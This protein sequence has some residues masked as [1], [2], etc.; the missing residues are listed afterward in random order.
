MLTLLLS[1]TLFIGIG[2]S[3]G[4]NNFNFHGTNVIYGSKLSQKVVITGIYYMNF[5]NPQY[6]D[7]VHNDLFQKGILSI[8]KK[9]DISFVKGKGPWVCE[10]N[11]DA[12]LANITQRNHDIVETNL[13][14]MDEGVSV[15][16]IGKVTIFSFDFD[17][18]KAKQFIP[19]QTCRPIVNMKRL[20]NTNLNEYNRKVF[21]FSI[22]HEFKSFAP[23]IFVDYF[24]MTAFHYKQKIT[25]QESLSS[26]GQPLRYCDGSSYGSTMYTPE[27]RPVCPTDTSNHRVHQ[28]GMITIYKPNIVTIS[29]AISRSLYGKTHL[30][31]GRYFLGEKYD[32]KPITTK[33]WPPSE[34]ECLGMRHNLTSKYGKLDPRG[35]G[36]YTLAAFNTHN[37]KTIHYPLWSSWSKDVFDAF[38]EKSV[39]K[40]LMPNMVMRTPWFGIP[41]PYLYKSTYSEQ[42]SRVVWDALVPEDLCLFVP[43]M[44]TEVNAIFYPDTNHLHEETSSSGS[45][46]MGIFI[47]DSVKGAWTVDDKMEINT[48]K[49]AN[50]NCIK[51]PSSNQKLYLLKT[52]EILIYTKDGRFFPKNMHANVW[53]AT[54]AHHEAHSSFVEISVDKGHVTSIHNQHKSGSDKGDGSTLDIAEMYKP[55][56]ENKLAPNKMEKPIP[57]GSLQGEKNASQE[58][59]QNYQTL[60]DQINYLEWQ[61]GEIQRSNVHQRAINNCHQNQLAWDTFTQ[62]LDI[63]PS[64]AIGARLK[65][66]VQATHAGNRVYSVKQCELILNNVI[67]PTLFT[68]SSRKFKING[69]EKGMSEIIQGLGVVPSDRKCLVYPLIKFRIR[70]SG[71]EM[72]GQLQTDGTIDTVHASHME[73]CQHNRELVFDI[74][75]NTSFFKDYILQATIPTKEVK[76]HERALMSAHAAV[77]KMTQNLNGIGFSLGLS[78]LDEFISKIHIIPITNPLLEKK[79]AHFPT[80][81]HSADPYSLNEKQSAIFALDELV[82]AKS[83]SDYA[84]RMWVQKTIIDYSGKEDG[85][86]FINVLGKGLKG[87]AN[88][89]GSTILDIGEGL[90]GGIEKVGAGIGKSI[91]HIGT[92]LGHGVGALGQ[93][94]SRLL[95]TI[96]LPVTGVILLAGGGYFVYRN[97]LQKSPTSETVYDNF[98]IDDSLNNNEVSQ[99]QLENNMRYRVNAFKQ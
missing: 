55:V 19:I 40:I 80:G 52:G 77:K 14:L 25:E 68:N 83:Y 27:D 73:D 89:I 92:G 81:L 16:Q 62:L 4:I 86:S 28:I 51:K 24:G 26:M 78:P 59:D 97:F 67:I 58:G 3:N 35:S 17:L 74:N 90:G 12:L 2:A 15:L 82:R 45:D 7:L 96:V 76:D 61:R 69:K 54:T 42:N 91:D 44:T 99:S 53:G 6:A 30:Y 88:F 9:F 57:S 71:F 29:R 37:D 13:K 46:T 98:E 18:N 22:T 50:L 48:T 65:Q 5:E 43:R 21:S 64:R 31:G 87:A 49:A 94:F 72:I 11:P 33:H 20:N 70:G 63:S 10:H 47:S 38:M 75:E 95:L 36:Q 85:G 66:A 41:R 23:L 32:N 93:S 39:M 8:G 60:Q 1:T 84:G 34:N 56:E 79:F